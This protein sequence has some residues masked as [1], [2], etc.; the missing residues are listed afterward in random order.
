MCQ[1]WQSNSANL[2]FSTRCTVLYVQAAQPH[3]TLI[4]TSVRLASQFPFN[5]RSSTCFIEPPLSSDSALEV[6]KKNKH[7]PGVGQTWGHGNIHR[8]F[9]IFPLKHQQSNSPC[10]KTTRCL[11]HSGTNKGTGQIPTRFL[12]PGYTN[13]SRYPKDMLWAHLVH[14]TSSSSS[15]DKNAMA[16]GLPSV[17]SCEPL[18]FELCEPLNP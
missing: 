7:V 6:S 11:S 14:R 9:P 8:V 5:L 12:W 2:S 17:R 16:A 1:I 18:G 10:G 13:T 4:L 15:R 3:N